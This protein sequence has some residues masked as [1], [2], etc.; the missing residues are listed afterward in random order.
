ME[1]TG[2]HHSPAALSLGK[3][4]GIQKN[5]KLGGPQNQYGRF[6]EERNLSLLPKLGTQT[7]E[8]QS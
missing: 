1:I 7:F 8:P 3:E 2:Q 4:S 6:K 5:R